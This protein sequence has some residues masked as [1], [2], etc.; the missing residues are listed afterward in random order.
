MLANLTIVSCYVL[1]FITSPLLSLWLFLILTLLVH[2]FVCVWGRGGD[3]MSHKFVNLII[4]WRNWLLLFF[5]LF[6]PGLYPFICA[7]PVS[8][9]LICKG[10]ICCSFSG[11][12][13]FFLFFSIW[14]RKLNSTFFIHLILYSK[15]LKNSWNPD[16]GSD[17]S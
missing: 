13:Y 8:I 16:S 9:P 4:F 11:V 6:I 15:V 14:L 5:S 12:T 7:L 2:P 10:L 3:A 1:M 17:T